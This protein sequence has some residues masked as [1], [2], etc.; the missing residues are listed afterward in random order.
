MILLT[1]IADFDMAV[2]YADPNAVPK[3]WRT[4]QPGFTIWILLTIPRVLLLIIFHAIYFIPRSLRQ[5]QQWTYRQAFMSWVIKFAFHIV[6]ELGYSQTPSLKAG[7][8]GDRWVVIDP[9]KSTSD[10]LYGPFRDASVK[11]ERIGGTWYPGAPSKLSGDDSLVVLSFHSGSFLWIKGRPS[12]SGVTA[13]LLN[14][15]LAPVQIGEAEG[16]RPL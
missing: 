10:E 1:I 11:P 5:H 13:D 2:S 6:T 8:L 4:R 3:G 14:R 15:T 12:D 9:I 16:E 7:S